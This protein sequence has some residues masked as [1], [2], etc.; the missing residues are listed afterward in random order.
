VDSEFTADERA[1][2]ESVFTLMSS[3][4]VM[5]G[6]LTSGDD[7][8]NETCFEFISVLL[9]WFHKPEYYQIINKIVKLA[10]SMVNTEKDV[11]NKHSYFLHKMLLS[12][13][14]AIS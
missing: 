1:I 4:G 3:E 14:G 5:T 13:Q 8:S 2:I 12:L 11:L 10:D 7:Y 6:I 9:G